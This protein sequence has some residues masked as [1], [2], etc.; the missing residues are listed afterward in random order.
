MTAHYRIA[1]DK[2]TAADVALE[3]PIEFS[4]PLPSIDYSSY[5][6][7]QAWREKVKRRPA[8]KQ[9]MDKNGEYDLKSLY[10]MF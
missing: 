8:Y 5:P 9:A 4:E 3:F 10:S 1:G 2:F 7:L 6:N